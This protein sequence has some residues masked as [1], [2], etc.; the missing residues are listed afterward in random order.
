MRHRARI[1]PSEVRR[2]REDQRM[3]ARAG[4]VGVRDGPNYGQ[5]RGNGE[6]DVVNGYPGPCG[7]LVWLGRKEA[8]K[9]LTRVVRARAVQ[10]RAEDIECRFY[11]CT[12]PACRSTQQDIWHLTSLG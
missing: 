8:S 7:K 5:G 1:S 3:L 6:Q 10:R 12:L 2:R 9:A 4:I 11:R